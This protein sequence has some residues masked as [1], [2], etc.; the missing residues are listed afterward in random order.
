M[1][2]QKITRVIGTYNFVILNLNFLKLPFLSQCTPPPKKKTLSSCPWQWRQR[3]RKPTGT[4]LERP[5]F[6]IGLDPIE[7]LHEL[8]I[9]KKNPKMNFSV[10][11]SAG[12]LKFLYHKY[13]LH[14][15]IS[16][17]TLCLGFHPVSLHTHTSDILWILLHPAHEIC[18]VD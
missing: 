8:M 10:D 15:K 17:F 2:A 13:I 3:S 11:P 18:N 16:C 14:K 9:T 6:T 5:C 7:F 12:A 4:N 1:E